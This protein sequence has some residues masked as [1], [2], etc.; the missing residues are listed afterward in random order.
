MTQ[1]S[2]KGLRKRIEANRF[3]DDDL[4]IEM[5]DNLYDMASECNDKESMGAALFY[6]GETLILSD[7]EEAE[8]YI[9]GCIPLL[10][11][12]NYELFA[13]AYN[14]LGIV[15]NNRDDLTNSLDF[16]L[17]CFQICEKYGINHVKGLCSCNIGVIFQLL[18]LYEKA[19]EYFNIAL[20]SF[21]KS[22]Q[23]DT[24]KMNMVTINI[25]L[26]I[27]YFNLH[28][29]PMMQ[30]CLDYIR[31][32]RE[33]LETQ[34][35][36]ELFEAE[37]M[38]ISGET[39]KLDETIKIAVEESKNQK[40]V[41]E[42]ID[43]Y[44]ML[45]DFLHDLGKND[46]LL[47]VLDLLEIEMNNFSLPRIRIKLIE[48]RLGCIKAKRDFDEYAKWTEEYIK[49]YELITQNYHQSV[50]NSIQLRMYI[51]KLKDSEQAYEEMAMCDGLT[52]LYNRYGLRKMADHL[53]QKATEEQQMVGVDIIDVDFFK[54]V[55]DNYGHAYGDDCIK[56]VADVLRKCCPVDENGRKKNAIV[57]RYGG[58]EFVVFIRNVNRD[59]M[60]KF[61]VTVKKEM[62]VLNIR[63]DKSPI[64]ASVTLSQGIVCKEASAS[65]NVRSLIESADK[66]LY[67]VKENGRNGYK[68]R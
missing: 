26:F 13:R 23:S 39:D 62:A 31:A 51:E 15:A 48:H 6:K 10:K 22:E 25:N 3:E 24:A 33:Y 60:E 59:E 17:K 56:N 28:D 37:M 18:E 68:V 30:N 8:K 47:E 49:T 19:T 35:S 14:L 44:V 65:D 40:M 38:Y 64:S 42:F 55:N 34:F 50:V 16:Y 66:A 5:C 46:M 2:I 57:S 36:V 45:C 67:E 4:Q 41:V 43:S 58:D 52:R 9:H 29:L 21:R 1:E 12:I 11:D 63:S 32:N 7:P 61:A 53:L 20:D 27:D 54:Q